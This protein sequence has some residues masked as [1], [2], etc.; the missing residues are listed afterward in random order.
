MLQK[1]EGK[2]GLT[3]DPGHPGAHSPASLAQISGAQI[4]QFLP[5]EV[6]PDVLDRVE[7]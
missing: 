5:L 3:A 7:L 4:G 1:G 2:L 6:T